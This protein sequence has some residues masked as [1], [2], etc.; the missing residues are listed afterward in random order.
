MGYRNSKPVFVLYIVCVSAFFASLN[1]NIYSPIIPLI[2]DSFHVSTTL[3]NLTV[4][5]FIFITAIM[6][7]IYGAI[8]D[9]KGSRFILLPSLI[10]T[11]FASIGCAVTHS[12]T[13]FLVFRSLQALGTAAI[14]LIAAATITDLFD[15]EERGSAM[16]T[17]QTLLSIAPAVAPILGGF[18][19][20]R[21]N[22]QG[23]FWSLVGISV[24][25]FTINLLFFPK[26]QKK[27]QTSKRSGLYFYRVMLKDKM[28]SLLLSLSFLNF[29]I[30]FSVLVYL[31]VLLTNHY[32]LNLKLVGLLYLPMTISLI[33]GSLLFKYIQRKI[34]LIT[35]FTLTN[36]VITFS[37]I[38]F[39]LTQTFSL[40]LMSLSLFVFGIGIGILT[41]SYATIL[42]HQFEQYRASAMGVFNFVRYIGMSI[43]PILS[44]IL[45]EV[46][47][48]KFVFTVFGIIF[49]M[50]SAFGCLL[51]YNTKNIDNSSSTDKPSF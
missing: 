18:I 17:Y 49:G 34:S 48:S 37:V 24:L 6:Q 27:Q 13:L 39:G 38:G 36:F 44:G 16:G 23:I 28:G 31:P 21:Y 20:D 26:D 7:I 32:H 10:L 8:L 30:Y 42:T 40:L 46:L 47:S 2:K 50:I 35:L 45:L 5:L 14:P 29:L 25:L 1:Q 11:V 51:M 41:P 22:Y 3:V 33:A 43:G 9:L 19:G 15:G 12:F 4:S